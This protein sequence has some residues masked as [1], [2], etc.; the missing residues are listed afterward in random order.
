MVVSA[1]K[2]TLMRVATRRVAPQFLSKVLNYYKFSP[3]DKKNFVNAYNQ[4]L[5]ALNNK[6]N[7]RA[8]MNARAAGTKLANTLFK[9]YNKQM[10]KNNPVA[11]GLTN[12]VSASAL[13]WLPGILFRHAVPRQ[14]VRTAPARVSRGKS[15]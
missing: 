12:G 7:T 14:R 8:R 5:N 13:Y 10:K 11:A 2:R 6:S 9:M 4:Y 3:T 1:A 15:L